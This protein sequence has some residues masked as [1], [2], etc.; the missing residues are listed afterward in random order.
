M[1]KFGFDASGTPPA[2]VPG[3]VAAWLATNPEAKQYDGKTIMAQY[4]GRISPR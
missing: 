4:V 3:A 1:A 2:D